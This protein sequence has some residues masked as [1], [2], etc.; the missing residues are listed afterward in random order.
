MHWDR[1][2]HPRFP[3][4]YSLLDLLDNLALGGLA[5]LGGGGGLHVRTSFSFFIAL[6]RFFSVSHYLVLLDR[7]AFSEPLFGCTLLLGHFFLD[8]PHVAFQHERR[9]EIR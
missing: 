7:C 5:P 6:V 9:Q 2:I 4:C 3:G 8:L 1:T